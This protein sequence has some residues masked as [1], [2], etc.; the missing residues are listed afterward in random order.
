[1]NAKLFL[2]ALV[3]GISILPLGYGSEAMSVNE[4]DT[5]DEQSAGIINSRRLLYTQDLVNL[6]FQDEEVEYEFVHPENYRTKYLYRVCSLPFKANNAI[7][8][9]ILHYMSDDADSY[10]LAIPEGNVIEM[11]KRIDITPRWESPVESEGDYAYKQFT[12]SDDFMIT[13]TTEAYSS[14]SE[15]HTKDTKYYRVSDS[16]VFYEIGYKQ[17]IEL[18]GRTMQ[19]P[20]SGKE[21]ENIEFQSVSEVISGLEELYCDKYLIYLNLPNIGAYQVLIVSNECGDFPFLSLVTLKDHKIV[22]KKAIYCEE[23]VNLENESERSSLSFCIDEGYTVRQ[24]LVSSN[25]N[26]KTESVS[27][28]EIDGNTGEFVELDTIKQPTDSK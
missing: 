7:P 1:M 20:I 17:E 19:L 2:T 6:E 27:L 10:I 25:E 9:V 3:V 22:D 8:L 26:G 24:H 11:D 18:P 13:V 14:N 15:E 12:I 23:W 16:G 21:I 28:F 5:Q 4:M